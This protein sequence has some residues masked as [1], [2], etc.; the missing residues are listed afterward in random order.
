[1]GWMEWVGWSG[2]TLTCWTLP[3]LYE[4]LVRKFLQRPLKLSETPHLV[5]Q[6]PLALTWPGI[7][8]ELW[9]QVVLFKGG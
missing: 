5:G 9:E 7:E 6:M 2:V 1:M 4:I 8:V 3:L